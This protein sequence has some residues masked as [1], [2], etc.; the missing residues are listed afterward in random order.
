MIMGQL[1]CTSH[2]IE[3]CMDEPKFE[4]RIQLASMRKKKCSKCDTNA[5]YELMD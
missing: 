1:L 4:S 3:A 2:M 5:E